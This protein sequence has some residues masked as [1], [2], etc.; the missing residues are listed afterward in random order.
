MADLSPIKLSDMIAAAAVDVNAIIYTAVSDENS[1]T[2]YVSRKTT[3]SALAETFLSTYGFPLLLTKTT[4]KTAI[5]AIN[6]LAPVKV[7]GTLL[8]GATSITLSDVAIT[9]TSMLKFYSDIWGLYP[10]SEPVV[11]AGSVTLTFE[12]QQTDALIVVEVRN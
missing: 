3:A 11:A 12:A 5:G 9:T 1:E 8:A 10:N 7:S 6:E 2:G 4:A